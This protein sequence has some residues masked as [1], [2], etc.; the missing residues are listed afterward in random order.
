MVASARLQSD[1][2][3]SLVE[4][5]I[6][7]AIVSIALTAIIKTLSQN[8]QATTYLENKTIAT[9]VGQQIVNEARVHVLTLSSNE[10]LNQSIV[11][12]GKEWYWQAKEEPTANHRINKIT[13]HVFA[14][15]DEEHPLASLESYTY[16]KT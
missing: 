3:L 2:G 8:V 5:L 11:F 12:L 6:A 15:R 16:E 10:E 4:V 9:W 7:L 13:V 14:T 1:H